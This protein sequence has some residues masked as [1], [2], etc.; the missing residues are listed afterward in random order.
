MTPE[1][2]SGTFVPAGDIR[3]L[4]RDDHRHILALYQLYLNAPTDSRHAVVDQIL[5]Q[6]ASHLQMEEELLYGEVRNC[7]EQGRR[8]VQEALLEHDEVKAMMS[9]LQQSE[10]DDDQALD[11]FFED[12]MQTVRA[13]F[14]AEERDMFPLVE[15]LPPHPLE[16][17]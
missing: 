16:Q 8:F 6:L 7:G 12:M 15:V 1:K 3:K 2:N 4:V 13:H 10:T 17:P 14:M 9:E 11:E 5:H